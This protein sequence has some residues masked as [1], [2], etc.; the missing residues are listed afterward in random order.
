MEV[1]GD[2]MERCP[3]K[4]PSAMG[5]GILKRTVWK[6]SWYFPAPIPTGPLTTPSKSCQHVLHSTS[7]GSPPIFT[8]L[9]SEHCFPFST[10]DLS[11]S[12][13]Q[14]NLAA[15]FSD[16]RAL[17]NMAPH[18]QPGKLSTPVGVCPGNYT[19]VHANTQVATVWQGLS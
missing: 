4:Y 13:L 6:C 10:T 1:L 8:A 5:G 2:G 7:L 16:S 9:A 17:E 14:H 15:V 3:R 12:D 11:L 18:K 19:S